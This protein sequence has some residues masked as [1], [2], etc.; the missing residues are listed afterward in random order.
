MALQHPYCRIAIE[1]RKAD[2]LRYRS[3]LLTAVHWRHILS[4]T[5]FQTPERKRHAGR[6]DE[7]AQRSRGRKW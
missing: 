6:L 1:L 5:K 7:L 2:K 4:A 3:L